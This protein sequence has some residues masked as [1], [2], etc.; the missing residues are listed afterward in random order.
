MAV[1]GYTCAGC[2]ELKP[3]GRLQSRNMEK[4]NHYLFHALIC[5]KYASMNRN[6]ENAFISENPRSESRKYI[7]VPTIFGV[8]RGLAT[9]KHFLKGRR[10]LKK[11]ETPP[12]QEV[13][14]IEVDDPTGYWTPACGVPTDS[15]TSTDKL[16]ASED[17][18]YRFECMQYLI[19]WQFC[20]RR[21]LNGSAPES[22]TC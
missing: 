17:L 8:F 15:E 7:L 20:V 22:G 2:V 13:K 11:K 1:K 16:N 14:I 10:S 6:L 19:G 12:H 21:Q 5:L 18:W 4:N 3:T 9:R